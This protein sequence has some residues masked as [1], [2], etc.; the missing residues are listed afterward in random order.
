MATIRIKTLE[1]ADAG[2]LDLND[3]VF[4]VEP[5]LDCVR[6]ALDQHQANRRAGTNSTK[7]RGQVRGGGR[8]PWRQKG[9]GRARQGSIRAPQWRGGAIVFGPQPRDYSYKLNRKVRRRAL[10][11]VLSDLAREGRIVAVEDLGITE[12]KTK[13]LAQ[14]LRGL[15]FDETVLIITE[16]RNE[17]LLLSARNLPWVACA[18]ADAPGIYEMLTHD[19]ILATTA[20]LKRLEGAYAS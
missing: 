11:S 2:A 14:T 3:A 1:G 10:L 6:A 19:A 18:T 13:K 8:K 9:T 4:G 16:E 15:G 12:P 7:T 20:A 17:P 5:N